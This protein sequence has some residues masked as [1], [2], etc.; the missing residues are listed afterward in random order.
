MKNIILIII[1]ITSVF[2]FDNESQV[3]SVG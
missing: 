2:S 1:T 3:N